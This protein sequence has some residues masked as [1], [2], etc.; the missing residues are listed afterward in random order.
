MI[1]LTNNEYFL[2]GCEES[3]YNQRIDHI[4]KYFHK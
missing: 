4:K 3:F 2:K 1:E